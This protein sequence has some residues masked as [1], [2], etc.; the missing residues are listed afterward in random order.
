MLPAFSKKSLPGNSSNSK[1][2]ISLV[3]SIL[4]KTSSYRNFRPAMPLK[5]ISKLFA[6]CGFKFSLKPSIPVGLLDNSFK[7]GV[8]KL[9]ELLK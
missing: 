2:K 8:S 3:T 4:N 7:V 5:P 6:S 1:G 9:V